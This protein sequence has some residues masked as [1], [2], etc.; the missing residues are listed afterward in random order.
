M[1]IEIRSHGFALTEAMRG[2]AARRL[3]FALGAAAGQ[4]RRVSVHLAEVSAPRS[5]AG[6]RCR[7][8]LLLAGGAD[9]VIEDIEAELYAAVDRAALRAGRCAARSLA[10]PSRRP[11]PK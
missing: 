3:R 6:K 1:R 10:Q 8:R 2:Y 4:V 9:V 7:V 11:E 5:A